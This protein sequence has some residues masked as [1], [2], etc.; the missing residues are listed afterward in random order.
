MVF[1]RLGAGHISLS[2]SGLGGHVGLG[3]AGGLAQL[4]QVHLEQL[5]LHLSLDA[6]RALRRKL[7]LGESV[8][9]LVQLH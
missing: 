3:N 5:L 9:P 2:H 8:R 6:R 4:L 7:A 1:S